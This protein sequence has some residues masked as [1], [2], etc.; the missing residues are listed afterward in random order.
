[1]YFDLYQM[2]FFDKMR[3]FDNA[4]RYISTKM[5]RADLVSL[6]TFDGRGVRLTHPFTDDRAA[7]GSAIEALAAA[8]DEERTSGVVFDTGGAFGDDSDAFNIFAT[9][10]QLSALQSAV[11]DLGP[12][13]ELKT[14]VYFGSGLKMNGTD[15]LAQ[16]RATVNAAVRANVTLNPIDARGLVATPPLGDASRPSPGGIGMFSG[17]IAQAATTRFQQSQDALYALA[18]DTGARA[19][20]DNNDLSLGIAQAAHAVTGYYILGFYSRNTATDGRFRRVKVSLAAGLAG[21][22]SYRAGY[23]GDKDFSKFNSADK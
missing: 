13:P 19:M 22:L 21:E 20:F 18:K 3:T 10:R 12:L 23:Y 9:D 8:A 15:N 11:T 1:L 2:P 4:Q 6:M 16:M 7:L 5:T 14:L 17:A